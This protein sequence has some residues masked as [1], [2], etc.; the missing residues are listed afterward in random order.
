[1]NNPLIPQSTP[2]PPTQNP[3][4]QKILQELREIRLKKDRIKLELDQRT[5][6]APTNI[7]SV[8]DENPLTFGDL[9]DPNSYQLP[10]A[11][12]RDT[13]PD[14]NIPGM[15]Y[16][17]E[18]L[19]SDMSSGFGD[20]LVDNYSSFSF[21]TDLSDFIPA[22]ASTVVGERLMNP[23]ATTSVIGQLKGKKSDSVDL[24]TETESL[25]EGEKEI[26]KAEKKFNKNKTKK[27]AKEQDKL[28]VLEAESQSLN[29]QRLKAEELERKSRIEFKQTKAA[30]T[31]AYT[32]SNTENLDPDQRK[33]VQEGVDKRYTEKQSALTSATEKVQQ[34][35]A[36]IANKQG[37]ISDQ[38]TKLYNADGGN[39]DKKGELTKL[40]K[41]LGLT[42]DD[43][44]NAEGSTRAERTRNAL[45]NKYQKSMGSRILNALT[46]G[47]YGNS[48]A[49]IEKAENLP[50]EEQKKYG[51]M[52]TGG[53]VAGMAM[54]LPA[55]HALFESGANV[56]KSK[57][58][59]EELEENEQYYIENLP[60]KLQKDKELFENFIIQN[61][62][63]SRVP[64]AKRKLSEINNLLNTQR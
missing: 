22:A 5:N 43:I 12:Y 47:K 18:S 10:P 2:L 8:F 60:I 33:I 4:H 35:D 64:E 40:Q 62:N 51:K 1:M 38:K 34:L 59:K 30:R 21:D 42:K 23:L 46:Y 9:V 32:P 56:T 54:T 17:Y 53:T 63:D 19:S 28:N 61:P 45:Q 7:P 16:D 14:N 57:E 36:E 13:T 27:I 29:D 50:P 55:I 11:N 3:E 24:K 26:N 31:A 41:E 44:K 58:F 15:D 37:K 6:P 48:D 39:F 20:Q 49:D 52:R 25:K